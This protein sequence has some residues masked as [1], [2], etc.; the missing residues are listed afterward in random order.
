MQLLESAS[1]MPG[2]GSVSP[3]GCRQ[4]VAD[5]LMPSRRPARSWRSYP[6]QLHDRV[7]HDREQDGERVEGKTPQMEPI[8]KEEGKEEK[9]RRRRQEEARRRRQGGEGRR[10][11][12]GGEQGEGKEEKARGENG[13]WRHGLVQGTH[14]FSAPCA[15]QPCTLR[16]DM[17]PRRSGVAMKRPSCESAADDGRD[18]K[19][20][21]PAP[22]P[23]SLP[24][25]CAC[26]RRQAGVPLSCRASV[27]NEDQSD[28]G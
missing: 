18:D 20:G 17:T 1:M 5:S 11:R 2:R 25:R 15:A 6:S 19:E 22:P 27:R 24:P 14:A 26:N 13:T 3:G 23:P 16:I 28:E 8:H 21:A 7:E 10:R 9:A 12:Q 4:N